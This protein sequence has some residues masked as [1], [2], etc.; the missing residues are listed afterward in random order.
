[1]TDLAASMGRLR[2]ILGQEARLMR[3]DPLPLMVMIVFPVV[4]MAFLKPAFRPALVEA[5][6]AGA[7]GAEHVV[8][9]QAVVSAFF[10]VSLVTFAFFSEHSQSTWDRLR[11]SPAASLEIVLGKA[12]PRIAL[13]IAQLIVI[14]ATGVLLFG[15][16]I[17]GSV[18]ALVPI[19]VALSVA[20]SLLGVA[21]TAICRTA[22]QANAFAIAGMVLVGAI[23]GALVPF[24]VLPDWAQWISP[25]TPTY[26]A[27]D[28]FEAVILDGDGMSAAVAPA[29]V[30]LGMGAAFTA[31]A[32]WRLRFDQ[33]KVGWV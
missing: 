14:F 7:N 29:G 17:K 3:R 5:G 15:L 11:A 28:G 27:M 31:L 26:W 21:V 13:G 25:V 1:V 12:L 2:V 20:L 23:G 8:P 18:W 6:H 16:E 9:G 30:L 4:T 22:Q 32:L 19:V 33:P 10:V 24:D